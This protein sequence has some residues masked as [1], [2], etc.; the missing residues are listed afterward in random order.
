MIALEGFWGHGLFTL[1]LATATLVRVDL[2]WNGFEDEGVVAGFYLSLD[3]RFVVFESTS[4][5]LVKNQDP[6]VHSFVL[7]RSQ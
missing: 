2:T 4:S 1:D 6:N 5:K 3:G 7:D